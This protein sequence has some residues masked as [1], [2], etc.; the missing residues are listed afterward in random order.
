MWPEPA[1]AAVWGGSLPS[2]PTRPYWPSPPWITKLGTSRWKTTPLYQP[3]VASAMK[4]PVAI[5]ARLASTLITIL[6]LAVVIVTVRVWPA[7]RAGGW[8]IG[9]EPVADEP[10]ADD[11]AGAGPIGSPPPPTQPLKA[12]PAASAMDRRTAP[13]E[14]AMGRWRTSIRRRPR[15][16]RGSR[17]P[18]TG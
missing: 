17:S 5:G 11:P 12:M 15:V 6:P 2:A 7:G 4:L 3:Q 8:L 16:Q 13:R 1:R 18:R 9:H 14:R 10:L